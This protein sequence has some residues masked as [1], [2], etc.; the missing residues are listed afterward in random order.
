MPKAPEIQNIKFQL[1]GVQVCLGVARFV[2]VGTYCDCRLV[3]E[4]GL[5][6]STAPA[7]LCVSVTQERMQCL[8][9]L[10]W[11]ISC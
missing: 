8:Q 10:H 2:G 7:N 6:F 4:L 11:M 5:T 1:V 9:I 3:V